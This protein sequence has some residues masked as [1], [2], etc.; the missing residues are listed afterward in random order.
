MLVLSRRCGEKLVIGDDI[1][2]TIVS[3]NGPRVRL[4][5]EAPRGVSI[6]REELRPLAEDQAVVPSSKEDLPT[7]V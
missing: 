4:G 1:I 5:L 6:R 3:V 2:V 7:P